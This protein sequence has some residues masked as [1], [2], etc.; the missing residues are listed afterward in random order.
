MTG[1][2]GLARFLAVFTETFGLGRAAAISAL[3]LVGSGTI[4][5][6]FWFFHSAPP[7]TITITSG[8]EGS[9]FQKSAEKYRAILARSGV[10]LKILPSAGSLENL[11]RL[12]DSSFRVDIGF[13]QS[14]VTN[15]I[16][17]ANLVSLGSVA[18]EPLLVF[19]RSAAPLDLLS[20][21]NGK[22][23]AIGPVGSGTRS[24]A[25]S[26]LA[27]NGI[28]PGGASVLLD[29]DAAAAT[30][31]L[32]AG[33]VDA[34]FLMGDSASTENMRELLRTPDV[35]LFDFTQADGYARRIH[36][37]NK[38]QLPQGVVDFGK[39]IPPH[40]VYLVAP[41]VELIA[42]TKLHPALVDLLLEAAREVHGNATL[43]QRRGEFPAPLEIDFRLGDE[44]RRYYTSGKSFLYRSLPFWL[45]SRVNRIL[46]VFVPMLFVLVPGLRLIPSAYQ[47]Q[48]RL[49]IYRSYRALLSVEREA[50]ANITPENRKELL[51]RVAH[52]EKTVNKMKVP[53]SFADQFYVLRQNIIFVR[54]KLTATPTPH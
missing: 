41:T 8:P 1:K 50:S 23:L 43:L 36:Y 37:L 40:D 20:D 26:L 49:R 17:T 33:T 2:P 46:V 5:A 4:F 30:K 7:H 12:G 54:N 52:I 45:A 6:V 24:L 21:L 47:W 34:V 44:A 18:Y 29:L 19:Y 27:A 3:L 10:K 35:R 14:G 25:I 39:N 15:G 16:N 22:R 32:L 42:R 28:E 38:L 31:A 13:V 11:K 53:A 51:T 48:I 9:A